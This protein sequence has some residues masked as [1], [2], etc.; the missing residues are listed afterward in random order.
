MWEQTTSQLECPRGLRRRF[1]AR[2]QRRLWLQLR[3]K[4]WCGCQLVAQNGCGWGA[5]RH[6]VE[7]NRI[8]GAALQERIHGGDVQQIIITGNSFLMGLD[9]PAITVKRAPLLSVNSD[10]QRINSAII[11]CRDDGTDV[12][13][14]TAGAGQFGVSGGGGVLSPL[15]MRLDDGPSALL[16][17]FWMQPF[18]IPGDPPCQHVRIGIRPVVDG[19][20]VFNSREHQ[21]GMI[22]AQ[23]RA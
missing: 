23:E 8:D 3:L 10:K 7:P 1:R 12:G 14:C 15:K 17:F 21:G 6:L 9:R 16:E 13:G 22:V 5:P 19:Q 20:E 4:I 18:R 2:E 11:G